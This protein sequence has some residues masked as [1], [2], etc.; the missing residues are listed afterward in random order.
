MRLQ[1]TL[2]FCTFISIAFPSQTHALLEDYRTR[3]NAEEL[4]YFIV[5]DRF[6]NG[7]PSN[8]TGG[9]DGG[10]LAH[11]FD[12]S[13][14]GFYHGGDLQGVIDKLDYLQA[15]GV[16]SLWL[17]PIFENKPVQGSAPW[18]STGYHGYWIKDF[19]RIDPHLGDS[20]TFKRLIQEAHARNIRV[21]L[22]IVVNHTAD[23]IQYRECHDP[24][25]PEHVE[26]CRYRSKHDYPYT[27]KQGDSTKPINPGFISDLPPHQ[28]QTNFEKLQDMQYAYTPFIP[29]QERL[30]KKPEWLNSPRYYHN[31]GESHW[32][33]ESSQYG[34]FAGLDDVMTEHP[35]VVSGFIEIYK[36]WISEYQFDGYRIDTVKH[37]NSEFWQAFIPAILEHATQEGIANFQVFAEVYS[38]DPK[39][40]AK[41]LKMDRFPAALDFPVQ[42]AI[43][44]IASGKAGPARMADVLRFDVLYNTEHSHA[45]WMPTFNGNH[46]MGRIGYFLQQDRQLDAA[47]L[48]EPETQQN[49]L[50]RSVLA[51]ALMVFQRGVPVLYYG[52][53]QGFIGD[54]H[55]Q[56][57][58]EPMFAH[59]TE[60]YADNVYISKSAPKNG[61]HFDQNAALYKAY[62]AINGLYWRYPALRRGSQTVLY[63]SDAPGLYAFTRTSEHQQLL[64]L[65]N[66]ADTSQRYTVPGEFKRIL[67]PVS[68]ECTANTQDQIELPALSYRVCEM[69]K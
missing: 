14:K 69:A 66:S 48:S 42:G 15:L 50:K 51:H 45:E 7:D 33:G 26:G 20:R 5:L 35:D 30:S 22:D 13:H 3:S 55:D 38:H 19:T 10:A 17:T 8:D 56:D 60:S 34:D 12:P 11:G 21:I 2:F 36:H 28:T 47:M 16:S 46:D 67:L 58:R 57:A 18:I 1:I 41:T 62:A 40:L 53:E 29:E 61:D 32:E 63:A 49:L 27:L 31:R 43:R 37:V 23:V 4:I 65:F 59:Q 44:D 25:Y 64:V 24:T 68:D 54:G 9:I 6:A 39:V 52:D